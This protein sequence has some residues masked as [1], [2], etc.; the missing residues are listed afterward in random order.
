[1][2]R[3][4]VLGASGM[5]GRAVVEAAIRAGHDVSAW[6]R[7]QCD[8]TSP[9][10][11]AQLAIEK[12]EVCVNCAAF[13]AVDVAETQRDAAWDANALGP[14]LVAQACALAQT[15][16]IHISSDFVFSG[17]STRPYR[18]EDPTAPLSWYGE[19]KLAGEH[20]ALEAGAL[21]VRTSW[22]FAHGSSSFPWAIIRAYRDGKPLRV[23]DDQTGTPTFAPSLARALIDLIALGPPPGV[24]HVAGPDACTRYEWA[25]RTLQAWRRRHLDA[26]V[27][28]IEPI[29]S[30]EWPT[31]ARRP[32]MSALDCGKMLEWGIAALPPLDAEL[33][34]LFAQDA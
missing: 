25:L 2:S 30:A 12:F 5:L 9:M 26:P 19:T 13:T 14:A 22:L 1:M 20:G 16:L 18:E 15:R 28:V 6:A 11:I 29:S 17:D 24:L 34:A 7:A 31:P 27:A 23:V 21:V 10:A 8:V 3:V 33:D 32:A 4:V